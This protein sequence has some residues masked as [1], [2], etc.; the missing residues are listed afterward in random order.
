MSRGGVVKIPWAALIQD[1]KIRKKSFGFRHIGWL[2]TVDSEGK[3]LYFNTGCRRWGILSI[4]RVQLFF[5]RTCG[6]NII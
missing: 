2:Q 4:F 3:M 5:L 6:V 1:L